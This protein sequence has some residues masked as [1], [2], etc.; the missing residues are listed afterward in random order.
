[1]VPIKISSLAVS[2]VLSK[3]GKKARERRTSQMWFKGT[4]IWPGRS[5]EADICF[6]HDVVLVWLCAK[7]DAV[8]AGVSDDMHN[9]CLRYLGMVE[10]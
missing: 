4:G 7:R 3:K 6:A 1:M 2:R 8:L 9:S 5:H 10:P